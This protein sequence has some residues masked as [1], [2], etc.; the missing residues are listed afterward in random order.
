MDPISRKRFRRDAPKDPISRT[1]TLKDIFKVRRNAG[2]SSSKAVSARREADI[3]KGKQ[4]RLAMRRQEAKDALRDIFE[5]RGH[6]TESYNAAVQS[7]FTKS[8][9]Q[10]AWLES[11]ALGAIAPYVGETALGSGM[12]NMVYQFLTP[13]VRKYMREVLY[14]EDQPNTHA[15]IKQAARAMINYF[16]E[17]Y[18]PH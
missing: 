10:N 3:Q 18:S 8:T 7:V 1:K 17:K 5:L 2:P 9:D 14:N 13:E 12:A 4:M 16:M 6:T 15:A 11:M